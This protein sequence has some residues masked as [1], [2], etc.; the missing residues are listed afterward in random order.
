MRHRQLVVFVVA[1]LLAACGGGGGGGDGGTTGAAVDAAGL[2][3][4][5]GATLYR[6]ADSGSPPPYT[7]IQPPNDRELQVDVRYGAVGSMA[8]TPILAETRIMPSFV[9][10][11]NHTPFCTLASGSLPAGLTL[12][13]D[14]S[15][16]GRAT[17]TGDM[18]SFV[19]RVGATGA[20]NTLD[21][22][23]AVI[24]Y[25]PTVKYGLF[26]QVVYTRTGYAVYDVPQIS[27]WRADTIGGS[28]KFR[29]K[30]ED[31]LPPGITFDP[32]TGVL[33]GTLQSAGDFRVEVIGTLTTQ[34]G[35]YEAPPARWMY[36]VTPEPSFS[37]RTAPLFTWDLGRSLY[38]EAQA[39]FGA[40]ADF[41]DFRVEGNVPLPAG[42]ALDPNGGYLWGVARELA[43]PHTYVISAYK[44]S[45]RTRTQTSIA[46]EVKQRVTITYASELTANARSDVSIS[47]LLKLNGSLATPTVAAAVPRAGACI[48]PAGLQI[49]P[50][51][52]KIS[53]NTSA[54]GTFEC[55]VDFR[56][57]SEGVTWDVPP[58][59]FRL[60]V[61]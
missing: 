55:T 18:G 31:S 22:S 1:C 13:R 12:Q 16:T 9:G 39:D 50:L 20:S 53:G 52:G 54:T 34:A 44:A 10:F 43:E 35:A 4:G 56:L 59:S 61:N 21:F 14:C 19:V 33:Q 23:G 27:D 60:T 48:L 58:S 11:G 57:T 25:G 5:G 30:Q 7:V 47:P 6:M 26:E 36:N 40:L 28:W 2:G 3:G 17:T 49:A 41:S 38:L 24:T 45:A 8:T 29:L 42:L 15:I 37:Y 32:N 46:I 51:T